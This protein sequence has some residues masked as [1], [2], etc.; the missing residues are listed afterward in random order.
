MADAGYD[1]EW[2]H[3]FWRYGVHARTVIP[4]VARGGYGVIKTPWRSRMNALFSASRSPA[5]YATRLCSESFHSGLKRSTGD[6]LTAR[7]DA[8]RYTEA[9]LRL[10][11]YQIRRA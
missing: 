7:T 6:K 10:L 1:A 5:G 11:A 9:G 4:P 8:A 2:L 3:E